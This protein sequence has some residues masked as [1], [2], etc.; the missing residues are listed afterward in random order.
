MVISETGLKIISETLRMIGGVMI[1]YT[2]IKVHYRFWKEHQIDA[3][4][5]TTMRKEQRAGILGIIFLV[6]G[7]LIQ[8]IILI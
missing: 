6:L 7:Y 5:F 3:D 4:V 2:A 8:I 1:A